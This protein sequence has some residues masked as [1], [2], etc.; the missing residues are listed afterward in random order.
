MFILEFI[1]KQCNDLSRV[2]YY[3]Y[4]GVKIQ[5]FDHPY[6]RL[7]NILKCSIEKKIFKIVLNNMQ[8]SK[9]S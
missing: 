9:F 6:L 2:D 3:G 4:V 8:S 7:V 1:S 5:T